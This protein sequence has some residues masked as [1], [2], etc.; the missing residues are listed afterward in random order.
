MA[1]PR[2]CPRCGSEGAGKFCSQCGAPLGR[3][4]ACGGCGAALKPEAL[5]C[6]ECGVPVGAREAKPRSARIPWAASALALAAFSILIAVLVQ[7][8][9][10]ER[11]GEMTMT[12][13]LP[14]ETA[15]PRGD[16]RGRHA[17]GGGTRGDDAA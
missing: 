2:E 17:D 7:R 10:M 11:V 5:Y 13:G 3:G 1:A 8:G 16:G 12:G 14:G 6:T 15:G 9:S 4:A